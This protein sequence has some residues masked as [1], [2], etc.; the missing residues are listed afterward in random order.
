MSDGNDRSWTADKP[1]K[2]TGA[3]GLSGESRDCAPL[4]SIKGCLFPRRFSFFS[5][6]SS[7][8]PDLA[9]T[10]PLTLAFTSKLGPLHSFELSPDHLL[11]LPASMDD[12]I[13]HSLWDWDDVTCTTP[14]LTSRDRSELGENAYT[15]PTLDESDEPNEEQAKAQQT[16]LSVPSIERYGI[17][18]RSG[19][20]RTRRTLQACPTAKCIV[21]LHAR[22][23]LKATR[24]LLRPS[25][26]RISDSRIGT[27]TTTLGSPTS[28]AQRS[29]PTALRRLK[30]RSV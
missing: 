26:A 27:S 18:P 24:V 22:K 23:I 15:G 7:L 17:R 4:R 11:Q 8:T 14:P 1:A 21:P 9:G 16:L 19:I 10:T 28:V 5:L 6:L 2:T 29:Q 13:R 30:A 20:Q 12:D 3:A 25:R